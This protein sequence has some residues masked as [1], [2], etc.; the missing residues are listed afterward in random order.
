[1][2]E[3]VARVILMPVT[4]EIEALALRLPEPFPRDLPDC[5]NASTAMVEG[6]PL[7]TA[8]ARGFGGQRC[9]LRSGRRRNSA[10]LKRPVSLGPSHSRGRLSPHFSFCPN[11][12]SYCVP[13]FRLQ[14]GLVPLRLGYNV[15]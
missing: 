1:M 15:L 2:R 3:T 7:V 9:W 14:G 5:L 11:I 12:L 6:M 8:D 10:W 13:T 4:V